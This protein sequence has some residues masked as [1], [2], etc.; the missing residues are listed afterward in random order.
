M[1]RY[2]AVGAT[3]IR[4]DLNG[5]IEVITDGTSL[6]AITFSAAQRQPRRH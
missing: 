1:A 2:E 4:T 5:Q 3:V 6:S